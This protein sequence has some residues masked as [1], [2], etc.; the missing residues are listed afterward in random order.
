MMTNSKDNW[1]LIKEKIYNTIDGNIRNICVYNTNLVDWEI[2]ISF[3]N[4]Q[5][6]IVFKNS[7]NNEQYNR[8]NLEIVRDILNKK[9]DNSYIAE[10]NMN[11][12]YIRLYFN[13]IDMLEMDIDIKDIRN[14]SDHQSFVDFLTK[15]S[16]VLN[17]S[18]F[19]ESETYFEEPKKFIEVYGNVPDWEL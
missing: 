13:I 8:I 5:Y 14:Y 17:K 16:I 1:S 3:L 7:Q 10:I 6:N 11:N 9:I 4:G 15:I 2:I 19:L 18:V 12:L